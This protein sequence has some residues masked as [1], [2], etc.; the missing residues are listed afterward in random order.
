MGELYR[1]CMIIISSFASL[2]LVSIGS[3]QLQPTVLKP[4]ENGIDLRT[5]HEFF[6]TSVAID[7]GGILVGT[8]LF[9]IENSEDPEAAYLFDATGNYLRPLNGGSVKP[10]DWDFGASV[11][12]DGSLFVIGA[13][14]IN[15]ERGSVFVF[16]GENMPVERMG[17]SSGDAYGTSTALD[18]VSA[19]IGAPIVKHGPRLNNAGSA[20]YYSDI[21]DNAVMPTEITAE[22]DIRIDDFFGTSV[23]MDNG[24]IVVGAPGGFPGVP[25]ERSG[26]AYVFDTAGNRQFKLTANQLGDS[27]G[28]SVDIS[29]SLVVV[30]APNAKPE[31]VGDAVELGTG[32]IHLFDLD[33][34]QVELCPPM[35]T[36]FEPT[37]MDLDLFGA[38]VAIDG[39]NIVV[40]APIA[41]HADNL[42]PGGAAY[43]YVLEN[44]GLTFVQK[45]KTVP[46]PMFGDAF[47]VSVDI[48]GDLVVVGASQSVEEACIA[49]DTDC[50]NTGSAYLYD[51]SQDQAPDLLAGDADQDFDFDQ[52]DL[53]KVQQ[54]AKYLTGQT[55]TWGE[56]DWNG[57]PGG[58][59]GNPRPGD[60]QFNPLDIVAALQSGVYLSGPYA[61]Q[62]NGPLTDELR[63]DTWLSANSDETL[64]GIARGSISSTMSSG[65]ARLSEVRAEGALNH[66]HLSGESSLIQVAVPEPSSL[67]IGVI[68]ILWSALC[69]IR[70]TRSGGCFV[71]VFALLGLTACP[72]F[73][74]GASSDPTGT[75][76]A[77]LSVEA[78]YGTQCAEDAQSND[79]EDPGKCV[80][81]HSENQLFARFFT[82][83]FKL[84]IDPPE[85]VEGKFTVEY[86]SDRMRLS[87][88]RYLDHY[89][90][91]A[92]LTISESEDGKSLVRIHARLAGTPQ[93]RSNINFVEVIFDDL[94]PQ[95][96]PSDPVFNVFADEANADF[97]RFVDETGVLL[98]PIPAS[99]VTPAL[100]VQVPIVTGVVP[101]GSLLDGDP[102]I[103]YRASN[104][105]LALDLPNNIQLTA[106]NIESEQGIFTGDPALGLG[107]P[108][109]LDLDN[110]IFKAVNPNDPDGL[111]GF[112][113]FSLGTV[114][115]PGLTPSQLADDLTIRASLAD[116]GGAAG[117]FDLAYLANPEP[118]TMS[119]LIMA[120]IA[121]LSTR[122]RWA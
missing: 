49:Q 87:A 7:D 11:A 9:R 62:T 17:A 86:E 81:I 105:E 33:Q 16:D 80:R 54:A 93:G 37:S 53:V 70:R 26:T 69:C 42:E 30:G 101:G 108:F 91:A 110:T 120:L 99:Q 118:S 114:A 57:G 19:V 14:K 8:D 44:G 85:L 89:E 109:D 50:Q 83:S 116:G 3:A 46:E 10:F 21:T 55:A 63:S 73:A 122:R 64:E 43:H 13:P 113:G 94:Q 48:S 71:L 25:P 52:L 119:I 74:L 39:Q 34:C 18:G 78:R 72:Q 66:P 1:G 41:R 115:V 96:P 112:G 117:V 65:E 88:V 6:G 82:N 51:L 56:G 28:F 98:D 90:E 59:E 61:A 79:T 60:G 76:A 107:G 31:A 36:Y 77:T 2:M 35:A 12:L 32:A 15:S 84:L 27:F 97:F 75:E 24:R 4:E 102:S 103:V 95:L 40:G 100:D 68:G 22:Q 106:I 111:N 104:G 121:T 5:S 38:S 92:P 47:G 67:A 29:G 23:E 45:F 20:Y 58:T